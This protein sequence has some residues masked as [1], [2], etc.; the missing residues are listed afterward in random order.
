MCLA[1]RGLDIGSTDGGPYRNIHRTVSVRVSKTG[2]APVRQVRVYAMRID[3]EEGNLAE[4]ILLL[5]PAE[6]LNPGDFRLQQVATYN[7]PGDTPQ[8][9]PWARSMCRSGRV[10]SM[11]GASE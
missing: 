10:T 8:S 11:M 9:T 6:D 5:G 2:N 7:D 1:V 4:P 3:P